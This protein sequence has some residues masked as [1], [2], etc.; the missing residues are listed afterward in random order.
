MMTTGVIP[1]QHR[2][3]GGISRLVVVS[4]LDGD[5][6]RQRHEG[7]CQDGDGHRRRCSGN[8]P[9]PIPVEIAQRKAERQ[10]RGRP[11]R[12]PVNKPRQS[13]DRGQVQDDDGDDDPDVERDDVVG[14]RHVDEIVD[15]DTDPNEHSNDRHDG[16]CDR[17][18]CWRGSC[19]S[20]LNPHEDVLPSH[21][22]R[23]EPTGD[24]RRQ[25]TDDQADDCVLPVDAVGQEVS[26]IG[27]A[28][29][30]HERIG[31]SDA[32]HYSEHRARRAEQQSLAD[33]H[34]HEVSSGCT[35]GSQ[36]SEHATL[37]ASPDGEGSSSDGGGDDR[38][39]NGGSQDQ[40]EDLAGDEAVIVRGTVGFPVLDAQAR[41]VEFRDLFLG[42]LRT[43]DV[44]DEIPIHDEWILGS[45]PES[46]FVAGPVPR[47]PCD[48]T[49]T[50][51]DGDV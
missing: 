22:P 49:L 15:D 13:Q 35:G 30:G 1:S 3:V 28:S 48:G 45:H 36:Q 19:L 44:I 34:T 8:R 5:A 46:R 21:L 18:T 14:A 6:V 41:R 47:Q 11:P 43:S 29:D 27:S 40:G 4:L 39:E 26:G 2:H 24:H 33:H 32:E 9:S 38:G 37:L 50:T 31:H 17:T 20:M 7:T 16:R 25:Q 23:R 12:Q 51:L 10:S 42:E